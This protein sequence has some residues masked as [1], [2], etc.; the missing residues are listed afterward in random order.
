MGL[1]GTR[2]H[3]DYTAMGNLAKISHRVPSTCAQHAIVSLIL[4]HSIQV[5]RSRWLLKNHH[6]FRP[7]PVLLQVAISGTTYP[8]L[9]LF[10]NLITCNS[11][12]ASD[13]LTCKNFYTGSKFPMSSNI[14][15]RVRANEYS[16][17]ASP[18]I[19]SVSLNCTCSCHGRRL[20][21][22]P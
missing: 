8:Q 9:T 17:N 19:W 5:G 11:T 3:E 15:V 14:V 20:I 18:S 13:C 22:V 16:T 1:L 21:S 4:I 12:A 6:L 7:S 2:L 10:P